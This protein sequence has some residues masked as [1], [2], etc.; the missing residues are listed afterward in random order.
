M[1]LRV[2]ECE[3]FTVDQAA[4]YRVPGYLI[5]Q[6]KL[7]VTGISELPE[8]GA[9][10]LLRCLSQAEALVREIIRPERSYLLQFGE[11]NPRLH[12]HVFPRSARLGAAYAAQVGERAPYNGARVV[13]WTWANHAAL[14]FTD[15]EL[16]AFL[17][18]ARAWM[19]ARG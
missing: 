15:E 14:G 3:F 10:Q 9:A 1:D 12:F 5:V 6:C 18:R 4:G 2:S 7:D 19:S 11:L 8:A 13:E 16:E 17:T